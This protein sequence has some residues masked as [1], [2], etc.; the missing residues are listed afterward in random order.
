MKPIV[1]H[2]TFRNTIWCRTYH[3]KQDMTFFSTKKH[4][5][6]PESIQQVFEENVSVARFKKLILFS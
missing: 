3:P 2:F 4:I 1:E 5:D 6:G